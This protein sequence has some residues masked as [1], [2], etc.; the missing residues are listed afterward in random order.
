V[1]AGRT[2]LAA[3]AACLAAAGCRPQAGAIRPPAP[4]NDPDVLSVLTFVPPTVNLDE[5]AD[6]EG[7]R[8]EAF[9][10]VRNEGPTV[11]A[12]GTLTFRAFPGRVTAG[13]LSAARPFARWP[14]S[15]ADLAAQV[16]RT[17]YGW[18]YEFLLLW[19]AHPPP[20]ETITLTATFESAGGRQVVAKPTYVNLGPL[21]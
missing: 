15:A 12:D 14:F 9:F 1:I 7:I 8:A 19:T 11:T 17:R 20:A 13:E 3:A 16:V 10:F 6:P 18:G 5:D 2:A 4:R 21:R